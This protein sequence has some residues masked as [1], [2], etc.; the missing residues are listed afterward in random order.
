[1]RHLL[2][3]L[4]LSSILGFDP[5][6]LLI[7]VF[8]LN[9]ASMSSPFT[10]TAMLRSQAKTATLVILVNLVL[11]AAWQIPETTLFIAI[12]F[13]VTYL[14]SFAVGGMSWAKAQNTQS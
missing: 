9:T 4:L 14:Y 5:E 12:S 1:M 2:F 6:Y 11:I 10:M 7:V 3:T 13:F 8:L